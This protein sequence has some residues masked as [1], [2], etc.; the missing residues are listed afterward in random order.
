MKKEDK[1][2]MVYLEDM[3]GP[4]W[5]QQLPLP[6]EAKVTLWRGRELHLQAWEL[7]KEDD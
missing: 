3:N 7:E 1:T 5:L 2:K 6:S 4:S